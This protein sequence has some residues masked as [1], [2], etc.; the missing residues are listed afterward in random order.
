MLNS[1]SKLTF[2]LLV[3]LVL[4]IF[5]SSTLQAEQQFPDVV[6]V[7][8]SSQ[9]QTYRFDVT[10]SSPYDSANRYADAFRVMSLEGEVFGVR[11]L[12]HD[13]ANEQPFTRSLSNVL[14]PQSITT[15]VIQGRDQKYGWG[16]SSKTLIL[17][18]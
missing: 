16:G 5:T 11:Q 10:L 8:V 4:S 15:V 7:A 13:H 14:I 2:R 18:K 3:S 1:V 17:T 12:L 9:G 6:A